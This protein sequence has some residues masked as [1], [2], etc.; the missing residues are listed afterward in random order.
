MPT[1][2]VLLLDDNLLVLRAV[3][4]ALRSQ[5]CD[6]VAVDS[7]EAAIVELNVKTFDLVLADFELGETVNGLD[8]LEHARFVAPTTT[9]ALAT[10]SDD[11]QF[12]NALDAGSIERFLSKP[13]S[14]DD[15]VAL[16]RFV[17]ARER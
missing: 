2:R 15:I 13:M 7:C 3:G 10:A 6:V 14:L 5:G 4:R 1:L 17:R 8:V 11:R 9:R 16:L 12:A